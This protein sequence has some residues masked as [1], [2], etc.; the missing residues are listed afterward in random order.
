MA[1]SWRFWILWLGLSVFASCG[2]W[3]TPAR[4]LIAI[5]RLREP[6]TDLAH[7]LP[8]DAREALNQRLDAHHAAG[9]PQIAVLIL[10][11]TQGEPVEDFA[12]RVAS[13]W[14]LGRAGK[15]DGILF[16]LATQDR[17]MRL[18]VGYGL[19]HCITDSTARAWLDELK[20][21]LVERH[22]AAA[23]D[24]LVERLIET[25]TRCR[26]APSAVSPRPTRRAPASPNLILW[27]LALP[28]GSLG[29]RLV[30]ALCG[31]RS[32]EGESTRSWRALGWLGALGWGAVLGGGPWILGWGWFYW[33]S[34]LVGSVMG[35]LF[36]WRRDRAGL[37]ATYLIAVTFLSFFSL[38]AISEPDLRVVLISGVSLLFGFIAYLGQLGSQQT[39]SGASLSSADE[40]Y[41]Y[42]RSG[43]ST[44]STSLTS[45]P[46][47]SFGSSP[48][49]GS[50]SSPSGGSGYS[51]GGYTG[52]GGSF[53][54]G[55]AS[56]SW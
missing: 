6:V 1:W 56:S 24:Q 33:P 51:G 26:A 20:P 54:G 32:A 36:L 44:P 41:A 16:V 13:A 29:G 11:T 47:V 48:L 7:A 3:S 10:P 31:R 35:W 8:E 53:G 5:P 50:S 49:F 17:R 23:T 15:D 19:E 40:I 52:G 37:T 18:E 27:L 43:T 25:T 45:A 21:K 39:F 46:D 14:K 55:G 38:V 42:M 28:L 34:A 4:A 9:H 2:F 30:F 12:L 22:Y